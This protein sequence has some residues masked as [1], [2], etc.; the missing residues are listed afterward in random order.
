MIKENQTLPWH[1][2]E[3]AIV[4]EKRWLL[5]VFD[6][7]EFGRTNDKQNY[8]ISLDEMLRQISISIVRGDIKVKELKTKQ[9][10]SLWVDNA[11]NVKELE[12]NER[13]GEEWHR[14]MMAII[15]NHFVEN[16][17]EVVN[18]PYLN[19]GRSDLGVYKDGYP[20]LF[21]EV[22]TTSLYKTWINLLTMPQCVFLF[23][24]SEYCALEF[25]TK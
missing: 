20:N 7:S 1:K 11:I 16:G 17:F 19:Q 24:P 6:F 21:V 10:N 14:N 22:G 15:K 4:K 23:V 2:V 8:L 12:N 5:E 18:E 9:A 13:H 3:V 25:K